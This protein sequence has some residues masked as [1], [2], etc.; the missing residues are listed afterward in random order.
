MER[1]FGGNLHASVFVIRICCKQLVTQCPIRNDQHRQRRNAMKSTIH[2][3]FTASQSACP[4]LMRPL[5]IVFFPQCSR[6][7][8]VNHVSVE[9]FQMRS[10]AEKE[11]N[12]WSCVNCT[13]SSTCHL[14][15]NN[16]ESSSCKPSFI[17]I[18]FIFMSLKEKTTRQN[19]SGGGDHL[20]CLTSSVSV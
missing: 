12:G 5:R 19:S 4:L 7:S 10:R 18:S 9:W 13:I 14:N 6:Q 8:T 3:C 2:L 15:V 1:A 16:V 17:V 11:N 20:L